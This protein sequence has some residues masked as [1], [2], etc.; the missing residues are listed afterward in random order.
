MTQATTSDSR[1]ADVC[2]VGGGLVGMAIALG[3][4][5]HGLKVAVLDE[6]DVALRASRGNFG[7][8]WVQGKGDT[9]PEYARVTRLSASL[10]PDLARRLRET[11]GID[12]QLEQRGGLYL[13]LTQEELEARTDMLTRMRDAAGGDYPFETLDLD[14]VRDYFPDIGDEVAGATWGPED[15]HLNPLLLLRAMTER[16]LA[17]GGVI[18][19][20]GRVQD[21]DRRGESFRI[22]TPAGVWSCAK[23]VLAAGLGNRD[24]APKVGLSAP[25]FPNRGQV[26][27]AERVRHF[28]DYPTGHVRQTGEGTVQIGDSKEDVGFDSGTTTDVMAQIAHRAVRLFPL[29]RDVKMVRAWGALRVMTPDGY[30][31]YEASR[32]CPG[33]YLVTCHSG[34]TLGALHEGPLADWIA[35]DETDLPLEV[36]HAQR[37]SL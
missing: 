29:L 3:L 33:A 19:N 31:I 34:V 37:F 30:P 22:T 6:G 9:M 7:L 35:S 17:Q 18:D 1:T 36:F 16:F 12:V 27:V 14:Q 2:L 23:V 20:G 4:Q 8:V 24:L 5:R 10:W 15:G 26:L 11:T 25:V 32:E 21:I 28:L 13:C